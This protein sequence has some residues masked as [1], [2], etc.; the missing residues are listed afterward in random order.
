MPTYRK[1]R[2][3]IYW[4][5]YFV[6]IFLAFQLFSRFNNEDNDISDVITGYLGASALAF[7]GMYLTLMIFD[8]DADTWKKIFLS[9]LILIFFIPFTF[10]AGLA[11]GASGN[12]AT[13]SVFTYPVALIINFIA[14]I[15]TRDEEEE[16]W[17][18]FVPHLSAIAGTLISLT[19]FGL[20]FLLN[21]FFLILFI[22]FILAILVALI[23]FIVKKVI[24]FFTERFYSKYY[25]K[26]EEAVEALD[27]DIENIEAVEEPLVAD[28]KVALDE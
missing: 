27:G 11:T 21:N 15:K 4:I 14:L 8:G 16:F 26:D 10:S 5:A 28:D 18:I 9:S 25:T 22:A 23:I 7:I 13:L 19:L 6:F 20:I 3:F 12:I 1:A 2:K 24:P 17:R